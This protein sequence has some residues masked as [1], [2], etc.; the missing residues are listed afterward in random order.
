MPRIVLCYPVEAEHLQRIAL[1]APDCEIVSAGQERIADEI[2]NAD[3]FCGHA[4]VPVPWDAVVARGQL[5]WIQSSA[6]GLDHCLVP[7]VI[8][9]EIPITSASGLFADQVAEQTLA[10]IYGLYRRLPTFLDQQREHRFERRPTWDLH[11]RT[12]GIVGLGGNGRRIAELLAPLGNR[13][14]AV[15]WYPQDRPP[16]VAELWGLERLDELL[17]AADLVI[18]GVPLNEH[19]EHLFDAERLSRMRSG[20]VLV[21]VARGPVVDEDALIEALRS[22]HLAGA[23]LDVTEIEPLPRT[24][25]LWDLPN[26]LITPHV[27]AQSNTRVDDSTKLFCVNLVRRRESRP[28]WNLVDKRLGFPAPHRRVPSLSAL[29]SEYDRIFCD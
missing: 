26:V 19:T 6:A 16:A 10:L 8:A 11:G 27:G 15:D 23:A 29:R 4:K 17:A 12:I 24:S 2:L 20:A 21:N 18:L 14:L 13:I 25:P 28:L 5:Q 22:G 1:A 3:I 9:S 7:S